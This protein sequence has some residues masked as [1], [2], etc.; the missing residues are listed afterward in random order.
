M[1]AEVGM[2]RLLLLL[3]GLAS[4][5][6]T[7]PLVP[8]DF[9][10]A[11]RAAIDMANATMDLG[12]SDLLMCTSHQLVPALLTDINLVGGSA[13]LGRA[14]RLRISFELQS[15]CESPGDIS[16]FV[17]PGNATDLAE[18]SVRKWRSS[19]PCGPT[20]SISRVIVIPP[21][22]L[23]S[24]LLRAR[25]ASPGGTA[26]T[27][28]G[29]QGNPVSSCVPKAPGAACERDCQ[30]AA[31]ETGALCLTVASGQP[32]CGRSCYGDAECAGLPDRPLCEPTAGSVCATGV[33]T[34]RSDAECPIGQH[35][36]SCACAPR[37][38]RGGTMCGCDADCALGTICS[39]SGFCVHPCA[40][41]ADC[42]GA[43][44]SKQCSNAT[45]SWPG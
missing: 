12:E 39:D 24:P 7:Q 42:P 26:M 25:D 21:D 5:C 32:F 3:L 28:F 18:V 20:Q 17:Q 35:V 40:T 13:V 37:E 33:A 29:T 11:D 14:I 6:R 23:S 31:A 44:D 9:G 2:R 36:V 4:A 8:A 38:A 1:P 34:C 16:V 41:A 43:P 45:C 15:A 10:A 22:L 27:L 19:L 30:C